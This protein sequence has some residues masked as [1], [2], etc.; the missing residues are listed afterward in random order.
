MFGMLDGERYG[1][2]NAIQSPKLVDWDLTKD[3]RHLSSC[4][5]TH[6][7]NNIAN[8]WQT[9]LHFSLFAMSIWRLVLGQFCR[10]KTRRRRTDS[11]HGNTRDPKLGPLNDN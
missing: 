6:V 7:S 3:S 1:G 8:Q 9:L 4:Q 5:M 2:A 10:K 11:M